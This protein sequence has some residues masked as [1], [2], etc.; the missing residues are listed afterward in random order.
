[1]RQLT[2]TPNLAQAWLKNIH[3]DQRRLNSERVR[4][5]R[6][7]M[8]SGR[9][10]LVPDAIAFDKRGY[11]INGR[12]R[13]EA[14]V[15]S[16]LILT[17]FVVTDM[18]PESFVF[19]DQGQKRTTRQLLKS[20]GKDSQQAEAYRVIAA[21]PKI[22]E[23]QKVSNQ[24]L[25]KIAEAYEPI[26]QQLNLSGVKFLTAPLRACL[27]LGVEYGLE[28]EVANRVPSILRTYE[29]ETDYEQ[30]VMK[31][32]RFKNQQQTTGQTGQKREWYAAQR[33]IQALIKKEKVSVL[34]RNSATI[35]P[36]RI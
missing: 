21:Y 29:P 34:T 4:S 31:W 14:L 17:F 28:P 19:T 12:H 16:N 13:L 20:Y 25:L 1:M 9:W 30:S 36:P 27:L 35:F 15:R 2:V 32:I 7:N 11:L 26:T 22:G 23:T 10:T 8:E 5:Y 33:L 18:N 6:E 24:R 3:P